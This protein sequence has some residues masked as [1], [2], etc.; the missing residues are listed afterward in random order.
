MS[1]FNISNLASHFKINRYGRI[2][3]KTGRNREPNS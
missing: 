2:N 3:E 1:D